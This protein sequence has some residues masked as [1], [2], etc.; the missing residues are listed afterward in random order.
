M[1]DLN[2]DWLKIRHA[3]CLA[4][5]VYNCA[6]RLRAFYKNVDVLIASVK[7]ISIKHRAIMSLFSGIGVP[8]VVI[9]TRWPTWLQATLYYADNLPE[10]KRIINMLHGEVVIIKRAKDT[11]K[12][13]N[14]L[15]DLV[16]IK[17]C[18][19]NLICMF[20][21]FGC[22]SYIIYSGHEILSDINLK[23]N[24]V[25]IKTYIESRLHDNDIRTISRLTD[26]GQEIFSSFTQR[27]STNIN[28]C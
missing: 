6:I 8:P 15:A 16:Y 25:N 18:Y 7:M 12:E 27:M 11:L 3:K 21:N 14:L 9:V 22:L 20:D 17:E 23:E 24:P 26:E 5:L 10:I 28:F 19:K 2:Q 13:M 1:K 4:H